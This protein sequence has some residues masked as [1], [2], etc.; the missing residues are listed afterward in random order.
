MVC[1]YRKRVPWCSLLHASESKDKLFSYYTTR[2]G[3]VKEGGGFDSYKF[4]VGAGHQ[5]VGI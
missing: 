4:S 1:Y 2:C 3:V 5:L